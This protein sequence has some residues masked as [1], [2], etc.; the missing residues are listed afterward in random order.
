M[1]MQVCNYAT[2]QSRLKH[3]MIRTA[4]ILVL[5]L[6]LMYFIYQAYLWRLKNP[7]YIPIGVIA[8]VLQCSFT[9]EHDID[10]PQQRYVDVDRRY[11]TSFQPDHIAYRQSTDYQVH[12]YITV[13]PTMTGL[14][15]QLQQYI[16]AVV[17]SDKYNLTFLT[18]TLPGNRN[19]CWDI[20]F[21]VHRDEIFLLD[22]SLSHLHSL[23]SNQVYIDHGYYGMIEAEQS[24]IRTINSCNQKQRQCLIT[25]GHTHIPPLN[26][27]V[28]CNP[29]IITQFRRKYCIQRLESHTNDIKMFTQYTLPGSVPVAVHYRA[30]DIAASDICNKRQPFHSVAQ[31]I[32]T[33][34]DVLHDQ[35]N[36]NVTFHIFSERPYIEEFQ[37]DIY[38]Q[39]IIDEHISNNVT[40]DNYFNSLTQHELLLERSVYTVLHLDTPGDITFHAM[41]VA[42]VFI[43][44]GS[45]YSTMCNLLRGGV[46]LAVH[47]TCSSY[48]T[49]LRKDGLF[50]VSQLITQ[51]DRYINSHDITQWG[52]YDRIDNCTDISDWPQLSTYHPDMTYAEQG[53]INPC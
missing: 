44:S 52:T 36:Y 41:T 35:Y 37:A 17:L 51:I 48:A 9:M 50:N 5:V 27:Q 34:Y 14:G 29:H 31:T 38:N 10:T 32:R 42:P 22:L 18:Y 49:L 7:N 39:F 26:Q 24:I 3:V 4:I 11:A 33:V 1:I 13:R 47:E 23:W 25:L 6:S 45:G 21:N 2:M 12:H 28:V 15:D 43:S 40:V 30:G 20:W 8:T 16:H 19:V 53:I 46:T